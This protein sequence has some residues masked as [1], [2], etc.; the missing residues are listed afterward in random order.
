MKYFINSSQTFC[1]N[2]VCIYQ[3]IIGSYRKKNE[4]GHFYSEQLSSSNTYRL[5][6][7]ILQYIKVSP[8]HCLKHTYQDTLLTFH[9][10][11]KT[12]KNPLKKQAHN[13]V[14]EQ[15]HMVKW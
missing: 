4:N 9:Q 15:T 6:T 7:P 13:F 12:T 11:E 14:C 5:V 2:F 1:K 3:N 10:C 8:H